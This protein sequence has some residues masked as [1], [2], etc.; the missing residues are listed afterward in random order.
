MELDTESPGVSLEA[1]F[2]GAVAYVSKASDISPSTEQ[3]LRLYGLFKQATVGPCTI[4]KPFFD[5]TGRYKW[6][7]FVQKK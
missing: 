1:S 2:Q 5:M 3:K 6:Y 4:S 7:G